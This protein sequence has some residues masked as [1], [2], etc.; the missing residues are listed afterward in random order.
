MATLLYLYLKFGVYDDAIDLVVEVLDE[1]EERRRE[2]ETG[3]GRGGKALAEWLP[4]ARLEQLEQ[5]IQAVVAD[6][7]S[8]LSATE[9]NRLVG[10]HKHLR[11]KLARYLQ[12]VDQRTF[13]LKQEG[14][15]AS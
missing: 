11:S 15:A 7:A 2:E 4:Y 13:G 1:K 6:A 5:Q 10:A 12:H 9:R 8:P 3:G 14:A